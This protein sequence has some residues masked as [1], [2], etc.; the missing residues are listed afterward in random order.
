MANA[1]EAAI[2]KILAGGL[3]TLRKRTVMPS[4][5]R[6]DFDDEAAQKG[7]TIDLFETETPD[8][9]DV[10]PSNTPPTTGDTKTA[11]TKI[12][13]DNWKEAPFYLTDKDILEATEGVV[14][15]AV[16]KAAKKLAEQI[17]SDIFSTYYRVYENVGSAG[18]APFSGGFGD[19][20]AARKVLNQNEADMDPRRM[21][22]SP[23][24]EENAINLSEFADS[25][26]S[27]DDQVITE[28]D[29]GRKLGFDW[30]Y[31][32]QVPS[33]T[34]GSLSSVTVDGAQTAGI[35]NN[36]IP[37]SGTSI[38]LNQGDIITFAN[39]SQSY[40]VTEDIS[41]LSND[42]KIEPAL[43]QDLSGGEAVSLDVSSD[44][45]V[46]LAFAQDAFA[47][48]I[49]PIADADLEDVA[50]TRTMQDPVTGIPLRVE[51]TREHKRT[52]WSFDVLYGTQ[53]IDPR[54]AVRVLGA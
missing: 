39:H 35:N 5:V 33:H 25:S 28:A 30:V 27:G 50:I 20:T 46:N 45:T 23:E 49:R 4:L 7:Q 19:A 13:L 18:S 40:A 24:A 37:L 3:A 1:L 51:V 29:I 11:E 44:H 41:S 31:D 22:V 36:S 16:E 32:Q 6:R 10:S 15:D 12:T 43:Q 2:P 26:F 53:S 9:R 17:N 52:Q 38:S 54:Q 48:A 34:T 47:L 14:P 8:V 42:L 21:V